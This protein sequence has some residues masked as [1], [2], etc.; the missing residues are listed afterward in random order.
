[1]SVADAHPPVGPTRSDVARLAGVS[2]AVVSY[3]LNDGPRPVAPATRDRVLH[4]IDELGYRPN[5]VARALRLRKTHTLGLLVP[6]NSNPYFAELAKALEDEAYAHGYALLLANSSDSPE[7]ERRQL[8]TLI[9]RQVDGLLVIGSSQHSIDAAAANVPI[10]LLDRAG[11]AGRLPSVVVDNR[12]GAHAGATH[13]LEH[14][15]FHVACISGPLSLPAARERFQGFLD[16]VGD[17]AGRRLAAEVPFTRDGGHRATLDL[18]RR[19]PRPDALLACSDL[20]GIGALHACWELNLRVPDDVAIIA[21]DGT[22]ESEYTNPPLS[23]I[24]QP[25]AEIAA[26]AIEKIINPAGGVSQSVHGY[27]VIGRRSCGCP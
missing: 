5:A 14:G 21:F 24:Q 27:T 22:Q 26:D 16:A 13:L 4:A 6:D 1:M 9:D 23:V 15:R 8:R 2:P 3:V 12:G 11:D 10:V 20:Q 19:D 17:S 18:L 25:I 7:R